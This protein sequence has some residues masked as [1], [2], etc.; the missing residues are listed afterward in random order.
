EEKPEDL[1]DSED[2][3]NSGADFAPE[4]LLA[5]PL[6]DDE[7]QDM[8][9]NQSPDQLFESNFDRDFD[10]DFDPDFDPDKDE[11]ADHGLEQQ[12]IAQ[13]QPMVHAWLDTHVPQIVQS[14]IERE[15]RRD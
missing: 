3:E 11:I 14:I 6:S 1:E 12:V 5:A 13:L 9:E 15:I 8:V 7:A 4:D 2:L 10:R